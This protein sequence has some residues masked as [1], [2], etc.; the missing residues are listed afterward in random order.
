MKQ[1]ISIVAAALVLGGCGPGAVDPKGLRLPAARYMAPLEEC[2]R[3]PSGPIK[4]DRAMRQHLAHVKSVC[5]QHRR[6]ARGLQAYARAVT[7]KK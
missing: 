7:S 4:G 6:T 2:P 3:T 5:A 1:M